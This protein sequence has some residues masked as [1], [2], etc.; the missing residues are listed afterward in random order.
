MVSILTAR[1]PAIAQ[2]ADSV[3]YNGRVVTMW[4]A[5]P[6]VQAFSIRGN[7]FLKVGSNDEVMIT[8]GPTTRKV[9]L[10]GHMYAS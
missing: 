7:R 6:V 9:D 5:R 10:H 4:D 2:A 3:Y 1:V 8:A